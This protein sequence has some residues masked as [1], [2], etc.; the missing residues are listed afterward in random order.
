MKILL[1]ILYI[2]LQINTFNYGNYSSAN[3]NNRYSSGN[4]PVEQTYRGIG[5]TTNYG[6]TFG[7]TTQQT[8]S[9]TYNPASNGN[10]GIRRAPGHD[11]SGNHY[12]TPFDFESGWEYYNYNGNW[13][14]Y[15]DR[16]WDWFL[17][18]GMGYQKWNGSGWSNISGSWENFWNDV[19][20]NGTQ[21]QPT[22]IGDVIVPLLILL[23]LYIGYDIFKKESVKKHK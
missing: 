5:Y 3:S 13:Y 1:T 11:A 17:H 19:G 6:N 7:Y 18:W 2:L 20:S 21:V 15:G 23:H 12:D 10:S 22:P 16:G 14:R 9:G 8:Y 4:V